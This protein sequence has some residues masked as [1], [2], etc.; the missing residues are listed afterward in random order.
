MI[1][2]LFSE[3]NRMIRKLNI[4]NNKWEKLNKIK[5]INDLHRNLGKLVNWVSKYADFNGLGHTVF[6]YLDR[7]D[8][9]CRKEDRQSERKNK[10]GALC[11]THAK[12]YGIIHRLGEGKLAWALFFSNMLIAKNFSSIFS[13]FFKGS[14]IF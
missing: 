12:I 7:I 2:S 13:I 3:I 10:Y 8:K 9:N 11:N 14:K 6:D 1:N 4:A 5:E